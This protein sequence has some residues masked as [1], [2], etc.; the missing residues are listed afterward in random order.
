MIVALSGYRGLIGN[1]LANELQKQGH[2]VI[3][4]KREDLYD[5]KG[6]K[7]AGLIS[8]ADAVIH[9][10]GSPILKRWTKKNRTEIYD[11][12]I[13]TTRNL[14]SAIRSLTLD[15]RPKIY[16]SASAIGIY[17]SGLTHSESSVNLAGHFAAQ[18]IRDWEQASDNLP[19]DVR[20]VVFRIGLVLDAKSL[21]IRQLKIPVLLFA[22]G[23]IGNGNQPFPFIHLKDVTGAILWSLQN[24]RAKGVYNLV[25][26]EQT[27]NKNFMQLFAR[28]LNRPSWLP[29]PRLPLKILF[30]QAAQLVY[31]S[32]AVIPGR[33]TNESYSFHFPYLDGALSDILG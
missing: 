6:G 15:Q 33:L 23:P 21:L 10:S 24:S 32:P 22:G 1:S 30:G 26:P 13:V 31:E 29:V 3:K 14:T 2:T 18:I 16:V 4:L 8:G 28:R 20:R 7:L 17:Q 5:Y 9:V 11:S 25:A 27:T 19:D 12:R